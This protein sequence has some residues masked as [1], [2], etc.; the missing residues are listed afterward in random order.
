LAWKVVY[1]A[2][3]RP[4]EGREVVG[5]EREVEVEWDIVQA[6]RSFVTVGLGTA[7][8]RDR[9]VS[10]IRMPAFPSPSLASQIRRR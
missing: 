2:R 5:E 9:R 7:A 4:K 6:R 10:I 3:W 8:L 1:Q